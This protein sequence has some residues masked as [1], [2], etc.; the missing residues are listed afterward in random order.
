MWYVYRHIKTITCVCYEI[1]YVLH[2]YNLLGGSDGKESA[3]N[4]GDLSSNPGSG[5]SPGEGNVTHSRILAW[6]IPWTEELGG[7]SP[8]GHKQLDMTEQ[9][10]LAKTCSPKQVG[11]KKRF[12][13]KC[14]IH[15]VFSSVQFSH[16]V[17]SDSLRPHES[18]HARPPCPS[19][20]PGVHSNSRPLSQWC[21]PAISSSVVPFFSC[22]QSLPASESFP[23][24]QLFA[25]GGQSTGVSALASLLPK[26]TQDWSPLEWTGW[27]S[28]HIY[29]YIYIY[30][31][32]IY[33]NVNSVTIMFI[34]CT[35][36]KCLILVKTSSYMMFLYHIKDILEYSKHEIR[37]DQ[38]SR[39]VVSDSL[40]P[41]ESQHARPPC[42]PPTPGVHSDSRPSSQWCHPAISS[43]VVP[44]SS[45][46]QSLPASESFPMSQLFA[47]A[48]YW[49]A[50]KQKKKNRRKEGILM[51]LI[52]MSHNYLTHYKCQLWMLLINVWIN[53][54]NIHDELILKI[55]IYYNISIHIFW[56]SLYMIIFIIL[57]HLW[58]GI[59]E[60]IHPN[61]SQSSF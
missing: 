49:K 42:P 52:F 3:C 61:L 2:V 28:L 6:R 13:L 15:G 32:V 9:L 38:I 46:P 45:C 50:N 41:H 54:F 31:Y 37:S 25:W 39:S 18:Q 56:N 16:S 8:W 17:V 1:W 59:I 55:C 27:L 40:R 21:H 36:G 47:W 48:K 43:S 58:T 11:G 23:V 51:P 57:R 5:R 26:N 19:P 12:M 29:I 24:S 53:E 34:S 44:F 20:T 4:V 60:Y 10:T 7:L 14:I 30:I 33:L 22:P 35:T